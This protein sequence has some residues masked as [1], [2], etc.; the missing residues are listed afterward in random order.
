MIVVPGGGSVSNGYLQLLFNSNNHIAS[1]KNVKSGQSLN[2]SFGFTQVLEKESTLLKVPDSVCDGSNV[3]T[4]VPDKGSRS[5]S[6]TTQVINV[7]NSIV[8]EG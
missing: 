1:L 2:L 6:P 8:G 3:Y 4:F 7:H 5:L